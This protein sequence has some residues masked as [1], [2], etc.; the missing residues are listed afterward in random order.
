MS[1]HAEELRPAN[2][3][4]FTAT[5]PL[6]MGRAELRMNTVATKLRACSARR[7]QIALAMNDLRS[8]SPDLDPKATPISPFEGFLQAVASPVLSPF[9]DL[10]AAVTSARTARLAT[11]PTSPRFMVRVADVGRPHRSTKRSYDYFSELNT[12]L[13]ERANRNGVEVQDQRSA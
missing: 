12:L 13:A 6:T 11:Q 8:G 9:D 1:V 5:V 7:R 3:L 2:Q 10:I 4:G